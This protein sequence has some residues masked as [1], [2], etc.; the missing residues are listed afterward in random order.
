MTGWWSGRTG[1]EDEFGENDFPVV[2]SEAGLVLGVGTFAVPGGDGEDGDECAAHALRGLVAAGEGADLDSVAVEELPAVGVSAD[3]EM[4]AG[5]EGGDGAVHR[6]T[7]RLVSG[8]TE[9]SS[10]HSRL[11]KGKLTS[12]LGDKGY[13]IDDSRAP[14]LDSPLLV[15][16]SGI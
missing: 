1:F 12:I 15:P 10:W 16:M 3:T 9:E 13:V 2:A 5:R 8:E 4:V 11:Y 6:V 7:G 14:R